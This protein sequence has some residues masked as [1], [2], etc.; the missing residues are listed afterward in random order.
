MEPSSNTLSPQMALSPSTQL[1][2]GPGPVR[3]VEL[4]QDRSREVVGSLGRQL[5]LRH[6]DAAIAALQRRATAA[7]EG[8][9]ASG[10]RH[11]KLAA[12]PSWLTTYAMPCNSISQPVL[13]L[14]LS[15]FV[16]H[17]ANTPQGDEYYAA[18][19]NYLHAAT[20]CRFVHQQNAAGETETSSSSPSSRTASAA[21]AR[22]DVAPEP[23]TEVQALAGAL[24]E[25]A[26][27]HSLADCKEG[28]ALSAA[29]RGVIFRFSNPKMM[30]RERAFFE[31]LH[32]LAR[33]AAVLT[34]PAALWPNV[35]RE[36]TRMGR[37]DFFNSTK[38]LAE[39][40]EDVSVH[41]IRSRDIYELRSMGLDNSKGSIED[42]F[43]SA[44]NWNRKAVHPLVSVTQRDALLAR[45]PTTSALVPTP[46][47]ELK[48]SLQKINAQATLQRSRSAAAG[49]GISKLLAG[50][51]SV[52]A[53]KPPWDSALNSGSGNS[54]PFACTELRAASAA[55]AAGTTFSAGHTSWT[56]GR[57]HTRADEARGH[58]S[59]VLS[60]D[61]KT[62]HRL[63]GDAGRRFLCGAHSAGSH[64]TSLGC[65]QDHW[66]RNLASKS[67]PPPAPEDRAAAEAASAR[68]PERTPHYLCNREQDVLRQAINDHATQQELAAFEESTRIYHAQR[69]QAADKLKR[70]KIDRGATCLSPLLSLPPS[71]SLSLPPSRSLVRARVLS[72][73]P[74]HTR[75]CRQPSEGHERWQGRKERPNQLLRAKANVSQTRRAAYKWRNRR[76]CLWY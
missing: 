29:Y 23:G 28:L 74:L 69:V 73:L 43:M 60:P 41:S 63:L 56:H 8:A 14:D 4:S 40:S 47:D 17:F 58:K 24:G 37:S 52:P 70:L 66:A 2:C 12:G 34:F 9:A 55:A 68:R 48:K 25:V 71:P 62:I 20:G 50:G 75:V 54:G 1:P 18:L 7:S 36:V 65:S 16:M 64:A 11:S 13:P 35:E 27:P 32:M 53:R 44:L 46:L 39:A 42:R 30:A 10:V 19:I 38:R 22:R 49:Q 15:N 51:A 5:W 72:P 45:S 26:F 6:K 33:E 57:A 21:S 61:G 76:P 3:G 67:R 31:L 59:A